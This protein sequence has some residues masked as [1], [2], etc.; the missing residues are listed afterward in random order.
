[1]VRR[2]RSL[3][4]VTG[5]VVALECS[6]DFE[7][8]FRLRCTLPFR[9]LR[10]FWC[11]WARPLNLKESRANVFAW[12]LRCTL[13]HLSSSLC[14]LLALCW[15]GSQTVQLGPPL[16]SEWCAGCHGQKKQS[17][18][19]L[20]SCGIRSRRGAPL[21]Y[22]WIALLYRRSHPERQRLCF[23]KRKSV[24]RNPCVSV[25]GVIIALV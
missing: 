4:G 7:V 24:V 5:L 21:N 25:C 2:V 22:G 23:G 11:T 10:F 14:E 13:E 8:E 19:K 1:M 3:R 20:W 18:M 17:S 6:P 15:L 12:R 16:R 9:V